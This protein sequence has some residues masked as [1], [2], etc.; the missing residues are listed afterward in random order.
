MIHNLDA[1]NVRMKSAFIVK[2]MNELTEVY[3]GKGHNVSAYHLEIVSSATS[4]C[5]M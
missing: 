4:S 1:V 2:M 5:S 3:R